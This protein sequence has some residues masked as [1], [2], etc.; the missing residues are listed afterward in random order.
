M[1]R[2]I[3]QPP[4]TGDA[5]LAELKQWLGISRPAEDTALIG[6]LDVSVAICEAFTGQAPLAQTV[7]EFIA[8]LAGWHE[9]TSR[10]VRAVISAQLVADDG[11]RQPLALDSVTLELQIAGTA[12]V[13]LL[14]PV[15]ARW[16]ALRLVVGIADDW[17][18]LPAPIRHGII[19]L[20][21][22]QYRDRD[23][24]GRAN[25]MPPAS[26]FALWRPWRNLRLA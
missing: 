16:V 7:E 19:R 20:A 2:I 24:D 25:T 8:P 17:V 5:A 9:L 15:A 1:E 14:R 3:V 4:A 18:T 12:C 13:Q 11:T 23:S 22:H 6:L 26:V 21:A 10:P